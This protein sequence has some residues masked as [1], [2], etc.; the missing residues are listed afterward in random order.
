MT[1]WVLPDGFTDASGT[2]SD[3]ENG[4]DN[5]TDTFA[6]VL[7]NGNAWNDRCYFDFS[8][9]VTNCT[10]IRVWVSI[11]ADADWSDFDVRV[12][13]GVDVDE[14]VIGSTIAQGQYVEANVNSVHTISYIHIRFQGLTAK[15]GQMRVHEIQAYGDGGPGGGSTPTLLLCKN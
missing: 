4:Y 8:V 14:I 6:Y 2:W 10:K 12:G 1:G 9:N 13:N 7:Q 11:A 15:F 3:E 5:N